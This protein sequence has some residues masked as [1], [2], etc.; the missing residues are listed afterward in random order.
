MKFKPDRLPPQLMDCFALLF[1]F[2]AAVT[3][4]LLMAIQEEKTTEPT[5]SQTADFIVT[6]TWAKLNS[7]VD[8]WAQYENG[9][10][11]ET[12]GFSRREVS[13]FIL[14]NDY[15]SSSYGESQNMVVARETM[16]INGKERGTYR[17][18]LHPYALR[19]VKSV[20]V[21]VTIE[22]T[23]PYKV[24]FDGV[25]EVT[26][27]TCFITFDIRE[28][29]VVNKITDPDLLKPFLYESQQ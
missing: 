12:C 10:I 18:A 11:L 8:L 16:A 7:D 15:T 9:D 25:V 6:V 22:Q 21:N 17:F 27:E 1:V 24:I 4:I 26:E 5:P 3:T 14:H 20:P 29:E 13:P 2:F 23:S 28:K 19:G